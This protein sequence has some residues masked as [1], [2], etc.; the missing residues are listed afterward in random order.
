MGGVV[1]LN[2]VA[3]YPVSDVVRAVV[4]ADSPFGGLSAIRVSLGEF[5]GP[6]VPAS[7]PA[8]EAMTNTAAWPPYS[9]GLASTLLGEGVGLLDIS[10][11][12][13]NVVPL[14]S[15]QLPQKVNI[16]FDVSDGT[17]LLNHSAIFGFCPAL[18]AIANFL[19]SL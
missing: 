3:R 10:N 4:A 14:R 15:Q 2:A 8:L 1:A 19:K 6:S 11:G 16:E 17:G 9:A 7:C 5:F 12:Y 13:D 18:I